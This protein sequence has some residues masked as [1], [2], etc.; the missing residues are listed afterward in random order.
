MKYVNATVRR[1]DRL[2]DETKALELLRN[3]EY[4]VLSMVSG[5]GGYGIPLNYVWDGDHSIYMHCAPEGR[6]WLALEK[7]PEVS[8]CIVG[9]VN[10]LPGKFTTEYESVVLFGKAHTH[11]TDEEKMKALHL[12]IDKLSSDFKDLGDKYAHKSFHRVEII[13]V[14][15]SEFS[16]K[17]KKVHTAD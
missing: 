7:N 17:Q 3:G 12:I 11:L 16:G 2:M 5:N 15:I 13:R 1:Q 10:L 4:G 14:D 8:F 6:K 9:K